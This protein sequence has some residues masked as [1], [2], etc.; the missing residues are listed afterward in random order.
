EAEA[1]VSAAKYPPRGHRSF[2]PTRASLDLVPYLPEAANEDTV[3]AVMIETPDG[4]TNLDEILAVPGVDMAY[5]GP[6]DLALGHGMPPG[7]PQP[8]EPE[9]TALI[10]RIAEACQRHGVI[11][12]IHCDSP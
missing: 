9:R 12:G 6:N 11:P 1:A 7:A 5:V 2:G 10:E 8:P 3:V 4:V